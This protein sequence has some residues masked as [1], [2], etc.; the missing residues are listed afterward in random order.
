MAQL[1]DCLSVKQVNSLSYFPAIL[2]EVIK[3]SSSNIL[4]TRIDLFLLLPC[5]NSSALITDQAKTHQDFL[6]ICKSEIFVL[7]MIL[8]K[9]Q[10]R[11]IRGF[12]V[13]DK[14]FLTCYT[15]RIRIIVHGI[16]KIYFL[17]PLIFNVF[18]YPNHKLCF[19]FAFLCL[20]YVQI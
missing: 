16:Q 11:H 20:W 5:C 2:M 17:P 3:R 18:E 13:T 9:H 15:F 6:F 14:V 19:M 1:T 4:S 12:E 8:V 7:L 10:S